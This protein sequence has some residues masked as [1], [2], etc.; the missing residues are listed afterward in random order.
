MGASTQ[1]KLKLQ[2]SNLR[3]AV[4]CPSSFD[5]IRFGGLPAIIKRVEN[6]A[7]IGIPF[8]GSVFAV[9]HIYNHGMTWIDLSAFVLF[10][11]SVGLGTA[12]G[13]HRYFSHKSF[14]TIPR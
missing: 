6:G 14:E 11:V 9:T 7:L 12:L 13:L 1:P 4:D 8:T 2:F 10:Y 3:K 5:G